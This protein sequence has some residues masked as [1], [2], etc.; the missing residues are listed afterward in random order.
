VN[1]LHELLNQTAIA[2]HLFNSNETTQ[3]LIHRN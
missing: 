1:E 2:T 3:F